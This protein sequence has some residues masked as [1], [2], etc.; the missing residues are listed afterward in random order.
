MNM[1]DWVRQRVL[2]LSM[3]PADLEQPVQVRLL[4]LSLLLCSTKTTTMRYSI[5]NE[6]RMLTV[7]VVGSMLEGGAVID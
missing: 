5:R 2:R 4:L 6:R 3:L 1:C 7:V